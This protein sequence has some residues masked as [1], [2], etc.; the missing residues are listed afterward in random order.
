M[1]SADEGNGQALGAETTGTTDAVQVRVG[2]SRQIVVDSQVDT[3]DVDTA[4]EDVGG[5]TDTLIEVLE[6]LV[7]ANALLLGHARVNGD[8]REVA[9]T[10]KLVELGRTLSALDEND[11]LVELQVVEE[12]VELAV[13]LALLQLEV[14]LLEAVKSELGILVDVVLGGVLH[15][16]L[17]DGLDLVGQS[18]REHH[19][20]LLLGSGTENL[21]DVATHVWGA[22]VSDSSHESRGQQPT[23]LV[24][25]LVAF[26]EDEDAHAAE[27]KNLVTDQRVETTRG[28]D[29][30]VRAG[31]LV[32]DG[33]NIL[34]DG[35]ATVEDTGLDV[36]KVLA[37]TVVLVADLERQLTSVAHDENGD[38]AGNR[39]NLLQGRKD[40]D[41]S[42][43]KT[44][45]GLA[46]D[47][48]TQEG[49]RNAGLLDYSIG[50]R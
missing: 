10:Q 17:A 40:E 24:E 26:V 14:V 45:L 22:L 2:V 33:L 47:V 23:N 11:D 37:E 5:D 28:S 25:H 29:D 19:D 32:L 16:L 3:L 6:L 38:L 41:C 46:D 34:L 1:I 42:L 15:E 31:V 18:G 13:L 7:A 36:R 35:S 4:A 30:D 43:A 21:L 8:G 9:F 12:I 39:L 27:T 50:R 49:L 48:A 20:L 44:G